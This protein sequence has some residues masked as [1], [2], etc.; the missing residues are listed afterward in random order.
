MKQLEPA[1][2]AD[3][4]NYRQ[5]FTNRRVAVTLFL[6]FSSGLP[7]A[8]TRNTLQAW[9]TVSGI[10]IVTIGALT[11]VAQP[12]V[13][14]FVW[15]PL[16]DRYVPPF[17]G[18]RRGWMLVTQVGLL[19]A[20]GAMAFMHP[21]TT[22]GWLSVLAFVVAFLSASQD[23]S[24]N[25]YMT[26]V[27]A[28]RERGIGAAVS[29][30]GYR[31]AMLISGGVALILADHY[32]WRVSYLIMAALMGVGICATLA[33][34]TP[35][36]EP[37]PPRN[38]RA[39]VVEPFTQFMG[40]PGAIALLALVILYKLGDAFAGS[41]TVPFLLRGVGFS[42]TDVGG[43][44]KVVGI[45]ATLVGVFFGG[46][47]L[48]KLGLF[49]SLML[50][51][52]LQ[53]VS[54]LTFMA[55]AVIGKNFPVMIAAIAVENIAWGM[56]TAAFLAFLMA[57]CDHRYTATQF[58]LLTALDSLGRVFAGP[59]AGYVQSAVGW[60]GFFFV[61]FLVALPGLFILWMLR[62]RVA[63]AEVAPS[64]QTA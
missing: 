35:Q 28:P 22:P 44:Y 62:H 4:L 8:L 5:L 32:G 36:A 42:L 40:R 12:Y 47:L 46:G 43:L 53:A 2:A 51:G 58:A 15:A 25:A 55:L 9:F 64:M 27:L 45:S 60:P 50:F 10:S 18:R 54:I 7:L 16:M 49:R 41:L 20:I 48:A 11:L 52:I 57:L 59:A 3:R 38:L 24:F 14:K 30:G 39:A 56:G 34:P 31:I 21:A 1:A 61:S 19:L 6:G 37:A 13:W 23:I 17:L 33:S 63:A 26:D 29:V